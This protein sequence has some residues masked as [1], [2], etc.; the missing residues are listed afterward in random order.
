MSLRSESK[1][2]FCMR[3]EKGPQ[4]ESAGLFDG[5]RLGSLDFNS[6]TAHPR[7]RGAV[8]HVENSLI[9]AVQIAPLEPLVVAPSDRR[10]C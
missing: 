7:N 8:G 5:L 1:F 3:N 2:T 4:L 6:Q 9:H 10:N